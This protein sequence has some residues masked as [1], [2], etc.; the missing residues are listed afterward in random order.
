[1]TKKDVRK[2]SLIVILGYMVSLCVIPMVSAESITLDGIVSET[3]WVDWISDSGYPS[4]SI[5]YTADDSDV[6]LGFILEGDTP[7]LKFAFRADAS[8]FLIKIVDGVF[9]FYPGDSSRPSWWGPKRSGLPS[10]VEV[11]IGITGGKHSIEVKISKDILGGY[12]EDMPDSFRLW[13][14]SSASD[15]SVPNYYPDHRNDWWFYRDDATDVTEIIEND[16]PPTFHVPEYPLGTILSLIS[17]MAAFGIM[18]KKVP[19]L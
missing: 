10:G 17:M 1:M 13:V 8:D 15:S 4:Y 18:T 5:Y 9:A 12:S 7:D 19:K 16:N 11:V 2:L 3:S 6:Y 14:M